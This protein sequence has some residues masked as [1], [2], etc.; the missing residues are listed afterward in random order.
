[1]SEFYDRLA[2]LYHLIFP[3][4]D[5]SIER[6]ATQLSSIIDERWPDAATV[7]AFQQLYACTRPGGGCLLTVRDY[8]QEDWRMG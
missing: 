7:L 6:Q 8:D 4:W 1:M 2:S 3:N 5:E